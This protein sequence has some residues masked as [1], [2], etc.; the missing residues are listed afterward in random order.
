MGRHRI[1][2]QVPFFFV[3]AWWIES[4]YNIASCGASFI[5]KSQFHPEKS[6]SSTVSSFV[7]FV[8]Q[9]VHIQLNLN[10]RW[11]LTCRH[12]LVSVRRSQRNMKHFRAYF[13]GLCTN[14]ISTVPDQVCGLP[15]YWLLCFHICWEPIL[16]SL[17]SINRLFPTMLL[18][19]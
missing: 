8:L 11:A 16:G 10:T 19:F 14:S 4:I 3:G 1:A 9:Y 17:Q 6:V 15:D 12:S 5:Q 2:L 7:C 18:V 13:L